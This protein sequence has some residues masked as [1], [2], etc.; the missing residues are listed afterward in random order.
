MIELE[1]IKITITKEN[2]YFIAEILWGGGEKDL[3]QGDN[4]PE[5]IKN[6]GD[7]MMLRVND[8]TISIRNSDV[9][10]SEVKE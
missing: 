6:I 1:V 9:L 2:K 7:V 8:E 3:T 5:V 4:F 10:G